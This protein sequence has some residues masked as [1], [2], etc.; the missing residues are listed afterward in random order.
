MSIDSARQTVGTLG[1]RLN[2][3]WGTVLPLAVVLAYADG[4]W[5]LTLRGAIGA[6]ERTQ[7]PFAGWAR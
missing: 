1:T 6:I 5:M 4:F 7:E 3:P 2:V